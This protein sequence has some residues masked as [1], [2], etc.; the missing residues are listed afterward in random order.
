CA[1]LISDNGGQRMAGEKT[2]AAPTK[3]KG[4]R[5]RSPSYPG[6]DLE[7]AIKRAQEFYNFE[8]RSAASIEVAVKHWG[9]NPNSGGGY[10]L[11]AALK[12]F[13]LMF[14]NGSGHARSV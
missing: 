11:I 8:K 3:A 14:D 6:I 12:A 5:V 4:S 1:R 13:R 9:F 2:S 10:V 7:E